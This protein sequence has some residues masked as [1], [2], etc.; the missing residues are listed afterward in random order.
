M[1]AATAL[2]DLSALPGNHFERLKGIGRANTASGSTIN[3]GFVL[4]GR[5]AQKA[6]QM[7]K[8]WI[9]T[10]RRTMKAIHP[11]EH[12]ALE[13]KEMGMSAAEF[14]RQISVPTNRV[15]QILN[16]RRSI[17]GDTALRL[18]HFSAPA[19]SFGS[20]YKPLMRSGWPSRS[21]ARRSEPCPQSRIF[22]WGMLDRLPVDGGR[23]CCF[24][25]HQ[26]S[27]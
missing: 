27:R 12:L 17:T 18:A 4:G 14:S 19:L 8:L 26:G 6:H 1:D 5:K 9:I 20:T 11:G 23:A 10:E 15:T 25:C 13:L 7:W 3:G 21:Q 24:S 2:R 16:G 22:K